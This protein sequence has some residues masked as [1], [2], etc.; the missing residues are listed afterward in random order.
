MAHNIPVPI[1]DADTEPFWEGCREHRLRFQKCRVCGH[2]RWPASIVCPSCWR[3]DTEWITASGKGIV[4]SFAVYHR[5]FDP[6]FESEIPYVIAVVQLVE[7]PKM[8]T[9]L[10]ECQPSDIECD[11]HVEVAWE[12]ISNNVSLPKFRLV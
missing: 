4:Y 9:N 3:N 5:A 2:I 11:M 1:P 10:V 12:D 6:A 7:G 8:I